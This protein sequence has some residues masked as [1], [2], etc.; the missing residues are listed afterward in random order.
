MSLILYWNIGLLACWRGGISLSGAPLLVHARIE[1]EVQDGSCR[2]APHHSPAFPPTLP[3]RALAGEGTEDIRARFPAALGPDL[4]AGGATSPQRS[5][6]R[7]SAGQRPSS[8]RRK[9]RRSGRYGRSCGAVPA[10]S[11]TSPG[12][13][14]RC[15]TEE[16]ELVHSAAHKC[17]IYWDLCPS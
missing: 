7:R 17:M 2:S 13:W 3:G 4:S 12:R 1:K 16:S 8:T 11:L 14:R 10:R 15:S 5:L 9:S 6:E